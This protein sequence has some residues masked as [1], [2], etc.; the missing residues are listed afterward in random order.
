VRTNPKSARQ[1][2]APEAFFNAAMRILG[3]RGADELTVD[4]LCA[5]LGVTKGSFY[6]HFES[7]AEFT[8]GLLTCWEGVL[9]QYLELTRAIAEPAGQLEALWPAGMSRPHEAEAALRAW[10]NTNPM[11]AT[12]IRRADQKMEAYAVEWISSFVDDPERARLLGHM[13]VCLITG[14]QQQRPVDRPRFSQLMAEFTST[15]LG[16]E[17]E[18]D[19]NRVRVIRMPSPSG[20]KPRS[21]KPAPRSPGSRR[22]AREPSP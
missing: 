3:E 8:T 14:A 12:V 15:N 18:V 2:L 10:A 21:A 13:W 11:V 6:H 22:T 20:P 19:H 4:S 7:T 16:I 5:H 9:D 17:L 1:R